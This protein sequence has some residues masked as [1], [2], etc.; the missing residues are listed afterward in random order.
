MGSKSD[1]NDKIVHVLHSPHNCQHIIEVHCCIRL[2][3]LPYESHIALQACRQHDTL[4][5]TTNDEN[6]A[7]LRTVHKYKNRNRNRSETNLKNNRKNNRKKSKTDTDVKHRHRPSSSLRACV[8][9]RQ[10]IDNA[11]CTR[12]MFN[13]RR[14]HHNGNLHND[15][16]H[17]IQHESDAI[18]RTYLADKRCKY[19]SVE[20]WHSNQSSRR[21]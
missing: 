11:R 10:A 7:R 13:V 17:R 12:C 15:R 9:E 3:G 6:R 18:W 20:A 16:P 8:H 4:I 5:L 14:R 21:T 1:K 19:L 2:P